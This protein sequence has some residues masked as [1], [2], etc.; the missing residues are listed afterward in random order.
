MPQNV[1][2]WLSINEELLN[3]GV[4]GPPEIA[5]LQDIE[6]VQDVLG[7]DVPMDDIVAVQV[8]DAAGHLPEIVARQILGEVGLLPNLLEQTSVCGE[9]QQQVYFT[10][11]VE[12]PVHF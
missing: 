7:L 2:L 3:G 8:S 4:N 5:D 9:L 12:E 11:V 6:A 10:F 1:C